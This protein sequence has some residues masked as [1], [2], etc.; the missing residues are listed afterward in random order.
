MDWYVYTTYYPGALRFAR[1]FF[2]GLHEQTDGDFRLCVGLDGVSSAELAEAAG[3]A[4]DALFVEALPG[5]SPIALRNRVLARLAGQCGAVVLVDGDDW[6]YPDRVEAAKRALEHA[7]VDVCSMDLVDEAG[8]PLGKTFVVEGCDSRSLHFNVCG[9]SNVAYRSEVLLSCLPAPEQSPLM[10][11]YVATRARFAGARFH[12]DARPRMAYRQY[13]AN[14]A[15]VVPPFDTGYLERVTGLVLTHLR[16]VEEGG[17]CARGDDARALREAVHRTREF[18]AWLAGRGERVENY[19]DSLNKMDRCF[20]WWEFVAHP[21]L[22]W[23][24]TS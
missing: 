22:E 20:R 13:G 10:D 17:M 2:R 21:E 6:L 12:C 19:V 14:T 18:A 8:A 16:L 5:E 15:R 24:W 1:D 11:W 4:V 3:C 7:D 9:F 23:I